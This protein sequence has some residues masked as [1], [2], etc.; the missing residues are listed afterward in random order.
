MLFPTAESLRLSWQGE[1]LLRNGITLLTACWSQFLSTLFVIAPKVMYPANRGIY[2]QSSSSPQPDV[3]GFN[4]L[5]SQINQD[6]HEQ[7]KQYDDDDLFFSLVIRLHRCLH[8]LQGS[9]SVPVM[10][11]HKPCCQTGA[12]AEI[13]RPSTR[14]WVIPPFLYM[15]QTWTF[16]ITTFI[17]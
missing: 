4:T 8:L 17:L 16:G 14:L 9:E 15:T 7:H 2:F 13:C 3:G 11:I 6:D 12:C 5:A 10:H 1:D